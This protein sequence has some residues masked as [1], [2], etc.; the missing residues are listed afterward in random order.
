MH[1]LN[2]EEEEMSRTQ[3]AES[4]VHRRLEKIEDRLALIEDRLGLAAGHITPPL[5]PTAIPEENGAL[6]SVDDE[7]SDE[8]IE[9]KIGFYWFAKF[10]IVILSIGIAFLLTFPY[11]NIP[12]Y[13]PSLF[14][15]VLSAGLLTGSSLLRK[16]F[17]LVSRYFFGSAFVLLF[18]SVLRLHFFSPLPFIENRPAVV[19]L[20]CLI[21]GGNIFMS[22]RRSSPS[23]AALGLIGGYAAA[24]V[25]DAPYFMFL[26]ITV[27]SGIAIY[28]KLTRQWDNVLLIAI[29]MSYSTHLF[30]LLNNPLVGNTLQLNRTQPINADFILIYLVIFALAV[31]FRKKE[32]VERGIAGVSSFVNCSLGFGVFVLSSEAALG[33]HAALACAGASIVF[34]SISI[35]FWIKEKSKYS[36]FFYSMTGY[37]VLSVAILIFSHI[38]DVFVWLSWQSVIVLATAILFRS[39]FIVVTNFTFYILLL[40]SYL[41]S[42]STVNAI[43]LSFGVIA[44]LSARIL[45]VQKHRLEIKTEAI[46]YTYLGAAFVIF[47]YALYYTVPEGY[48]PLSWMGVALFYYMMHRFLRNQRYQLMSLLTLILTVLYVAFVGIVKLDPALRI[49]SLLALGIVLLTISIV[50]AKIKRNQKAPEG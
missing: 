34:L 6:S 43:S 16:S 33:N 3:D 9:Y 12:G 39:R 10:G 22:L 37:L 31:I 17:D 11:Q 5:F 21:V 40:L 35:W 27:L 18:F 20:L 7:S 29:V 41:V 1:R 26:A 28:V 15:F 44:L 38:P 42:A 49:V 48:V 36:T 4:D 45:N 30:W 46:R 50:Y 32:D 23:L 24:M 13:L 19:L 14:G 8:T 2:A 47:P 25:S